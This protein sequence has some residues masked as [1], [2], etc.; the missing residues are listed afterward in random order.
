[1]RPAFLAAIA[2][3]APLSLAQTPLA[4]VGET[5]RT[6]YAAFPLTITL[7]G[8]LDDWAG[9]PKVVVTTGT[10]PGADPAEN[11]SLTFAA[12]ADAENLYVL[13]LVPDKAIVTG[14]HPGEP[15]LEDSVE[16]YLNASGDLT[17][18]SY[19]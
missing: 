10:Q 3:L 5:G 4:P 12:V 9:I 15:W 2:A 8:K 7:D 16:V 17:A 18:T 19:G 14:T 11:G 13:A 6:Y 1:M